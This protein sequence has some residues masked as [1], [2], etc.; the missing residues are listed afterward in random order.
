MPNMLE[1]RRE[2][3][4]LSRISDTVSAILDQSAHAVWYAMGAE[5]FGPG[6]PAEG[7]I[8]PVSGTVRVQRSD[9]ARQVTLYR[10]RAGDGCALTT[11]CR[12]SFEARDVKG[13]AETEVETIVV[14]RGAFDQLMAV[15]KEFRAA[16][17]EVCARRI[18]DLFVVVEETASGRIRNRLAARLAEM[19]GPVRIESARQ[20]LSVALGT[21]PNVVAQHL[22]EFERRGW[23][24]MQGGWIEFRNMATIRK[25]A[26]A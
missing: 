5:L 26:L 3:P 14:P 12:L 15:S 11:A 22:D 6:H 10:A 17:F 19:R 9:G 7:L 13:I 24:T 20:Q 23:I 8:V 1:W 21:P 18:S 2:L 4:E 16:I 25:L